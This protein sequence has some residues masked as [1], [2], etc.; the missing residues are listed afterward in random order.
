[1]ERQKIINLYRL[2]E[3]ET[4]LIDNYLKDLKE[5]NKSINLVGFSTLK[6]PWDRHI[7]D[8]LQLTR[9]ISNKNA[10]IIDLGTGAGIPGLPISICGYNNLTMVDSKYKKINFIKNFVIKHKIQCKTICKRVEK[11]KNMSF[12]Y[13][14]CR[15]FAPLVDILNYSLLFQKRNTTIL[16]LKGRNVINE[17][18][19]SKKIYKFEHNLFDSS[20]IGGGFVLEIN[21]L[22]KLW[23][24]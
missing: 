18:K 16:L 6:N 14:I 20:S 7:N 19:K 24:K 22:K 17:I 2:K 13:I 23:K 3:K 8:S 12:D 11:I 1:M 15:A 10:K 21:K 4:S 9:F 5:T